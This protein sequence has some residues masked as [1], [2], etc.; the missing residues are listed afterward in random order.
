MDIY[1]DQFLKGKNLADPQ[2]ASMWVLQLPTLNTLPN[3][4]TTSGGYV[5]NATP[6]NP[7]S[8]DLYV[9][10]TTLPLRKLEYEKTNTNLITPKGRAQYSSFSMTFIETSDWVISQYFDYWMN[11]IYDFSDN[12]QLYKVGFEYNKLDMT[13]LF[14][15]MYNTQPNALFALASTFQQANLFNQGW[16]IY[17]TSAYTIKRALPVGFE[18]ISLSNEDEGPLEL[19]IEFECEFIDI[20]RSNRILKESSMNVIQNP[21]A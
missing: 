13:L 2:F 8:M 21:Y 15:K 5:G 17:Q 16:K 1:S 19:E 4:P 11:S 10:S 9:K 14:I 3:P 18:D 20:D 12:Q 6:L 7:L